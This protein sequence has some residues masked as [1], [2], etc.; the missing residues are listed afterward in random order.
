MPI[1]V[2]EFFRLLPPGN[3]SSTRNFEKLIAV[4]RQPVLDASDVA[5]AVANIQPAIRQ[6]QGNAAAFE[7]LQNNYSVPTTP[8]GFKWVIHEAVGGMR[9]FDENEDL[10]GSMMYLHAQEGVR[11]IISIESDGV[12]RWAHNWTAFDNTKWFG[13]FLADWHAP[14]VEHLDAYCKLVDERR[15]AGNVVTH[16]WGGTGRTGCFLA[17]Y[18]IYAEGLPAHR[19]FT[20]VR[21]R[22]NKHS[23]EMKAQYNALARY[24]DYLQRETS[25]P[26]ESPLLNHAG[27][28]WHT[29]EPTPHGNDGIGVDPG[30][31][32]V[33]GP[34]WKPDV[35]NKVMISAAGRGNS[36][37]PYVSFDQHMKP[38][39]V[40]H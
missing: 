1:D 24:A 5:N 27:G 26:V 34:E 25:F 40:G 2:N 29:D 37:P 6:S 20:A 28:H 15:R 32:G 10:L 18:L 11:T 22:Y 7:Y 23:V 14:S 21:Q 35:N 31:K 33:H 16:C 3:V 39:E 17:A 36:V 19:A 12:E 13:S 4:L 9:K 30:H 8:E 38:Q